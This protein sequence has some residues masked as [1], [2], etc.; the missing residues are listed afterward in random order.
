MT[1]LPSSARQKKHKQETGQSAKELICPSQSLQHEH[2]LKASVLFNQTT[3]KI[4][5]SFIVEM[6][7]SRHYEKL[8]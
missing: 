7:I 2:T 1:Q 3:S 8:I 6:F 4:L 5:I